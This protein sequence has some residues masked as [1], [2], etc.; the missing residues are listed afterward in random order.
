MDIAYAIA[1]QI[2]G[3]KFGHTGTSQNSAY[4]TAQ[5]K[6]R[7]QN[8]AAK[9]AQP[10]QWRRSSLRGERRHCGFLASAS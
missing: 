10:K 4:K 2:P 1:A 8:S 3:H 5:P 6:Q 9:T 7:S